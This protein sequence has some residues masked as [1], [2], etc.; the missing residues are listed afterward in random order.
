MAL[1]DWKKQLKNDYWVK[2]AFSH[3][4]QHIFINETPSK[5]YVVFLIDGFPLQPKEKKRFKTKSQALKFAK[6]YMRIH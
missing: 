4:P 5:K 6:E 3:N 1:K 2:G